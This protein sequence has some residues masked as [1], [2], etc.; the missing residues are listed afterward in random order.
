MVI[1]TY[2]E[3]VARV[4]DRRIEMRDGAIVPQS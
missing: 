2:S 3:E 1:V 4:P